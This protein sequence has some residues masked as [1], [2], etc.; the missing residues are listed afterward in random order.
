MTGDPA[1]TSLTDRIDLDRFWRYATP[2]AVCGLIVSTL[3]AAASYMPNVPQVPSGVTVVLFLGVFPVH[4]GTVLCIKRLGGRS[5]VDLLRAVPVAVGAF[6]AAFFVA[7]WLVAMTTMLGS[8]GS[9]EERGD[10]YFLNDHGD[11]REISRD[12]Y[13]RRKASQQRLF[14][15]GPAAFYAVAVVAG[16]AYPRVRP[17]DPPDELPRMTSS[18]SSTS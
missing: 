7:A 14:S 6:G 17:A 3:V 2:T 16:V 11:R 13:L 18:E 12:D 4:L 8:G 9:P 15:A 5:P 1:G 10:A